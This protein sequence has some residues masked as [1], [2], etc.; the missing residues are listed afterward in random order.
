MTQAINLKIYEKEMSKTDPIYK[1]QQ[2]QKI[3]ENNKR[4]SKIYNWHDIAARTENVYN[5]ITRRTSHSDII[6][7]LKAFLTF[8]SV[9]GIFAIFTVII[10]FMVFLMLDYGT[11]CWLLGESGCRESDIDIKRNT[12]NY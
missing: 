1:W 6:S 7:K 4:L 9:V 11:L 8:G 5:H 2:Y 10:D 3:V 12:C